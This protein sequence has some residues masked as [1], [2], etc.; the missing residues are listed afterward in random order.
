MC[1]SGPVQIH[2]ILQA[3][4]G[5]GIDPTDHGQDPLSLPG[6]SLQRQPPDGGLAD[7]RGNPD[8]S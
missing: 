4:A 6:G 5:A 2:A 3:H 7:Q 1:A 8:Q